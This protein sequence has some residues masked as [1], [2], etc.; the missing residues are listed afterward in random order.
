VANSVYPED[1]HQL[2]ELKGPRVD[3]LHLWSALTDP[4]FGCFRREN[5]SVV[6]ERTARE[7]LRECETFFAAGAPGDVALFYFSGHGRRSG[8]E[9]VLCARDTESSHLISSGVAAESLRKIMADSIADVI[10][11][12]LD[13]CHSGA[14]KGD[15]LAADFAGDGRYVIAASGATQLAKDAAEVGLASPFTEV[16]CEGLASAP[17]DA[18]V[19][20]LDLERLY[21]FTAAKLRRS[22]HTPHHKFQGSASEFAIARRADTDKS[23]TDG[24]GVQAAPTEQPYRIPRAARD[25]P[26]FGQLRSFWHKRRT[27]GDISVGD[28]RTWLV[29]VALGLI[30]A[31]SS[32]GGLRTWDP[33]YVNSGATMVEELDPRRNVCF[34]VM[35]MSLLVVL[36]SSWEGYLS[37]RLPTSG[38]PL[39]AMMSALDRPALKLARRCRQYASILAALP[40]FS[41]IAGFENYHFFWCLALAAVGG[42]ALIAIVGIVQYGSDTLLGG[43]LL[44]AVSVLLPAD[45]VDGDLVVGIATVPGFVALLSAAALVVGWYFAAPSPYFLPVAMLSAPLFLS[46]LYGA[47]FVAPFVTLIAFLTILIAVA[48]GNGRVISALSN[49]SGRNAESLPAA[50]RA[51]NR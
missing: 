21:K 37:R 44:M 32:Y 26:E 41:S 42:L 31:A 39:R 4:G 51:E 30:G 7:I 50:A 16:L 40:A 18:G 10:I 33:R 3:G 25:E 49:S 13:C 2:P 11:V 34:L 8:S 1:P 28:L 29:C 36:L 14:F 17:N 46:G 12:V 45:R 35:G 27:R 9:L 23:S 15:E 47:Y 19:P 5:V 20:H 38:A 48:T 24:Q 6:L 22:G 43:S